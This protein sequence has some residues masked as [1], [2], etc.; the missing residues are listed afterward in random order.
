MFYLSFCIDKMDM[1]PIEMHIARIANILRVE[2][3]LKKSSRIDI[4]IAVV[5][6]KFDVLHSFSGR[7]FAIKSV[8]LFRNGAFASYARM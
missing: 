6:S 1:R 3:G 5:L 8:G 2:Y 4:P 7:K